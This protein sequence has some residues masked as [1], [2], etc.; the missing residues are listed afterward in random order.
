M[1]QTESEGWRRPPSHSTVRQQELSL[2]KSKGG[3]CS[4][5]ADWRRPPTVQSA[6]CFT[7]AMDSNGSLIQKH[8]HRST[9][10]SVWP[11]I[12]APCGPVRLTFTHSKKPFL[13]EDIIKQSSFSVCNTAL[14][15]QN[16]IGSQLRAT[17]IFQTYSF[18]SLLDSSH[19]VSPLTVLITPVHAVSP[20]IPTV[21]RGTCGPPSDQTSSTRVVDHF[22]FLGWEH[23]SLEYYLTVSAG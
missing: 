12:W 11:N 22:H 7:W 9:Q 15:G 21:G 17:P 1:L 18:L 2:I 3:V 20:P 19:S 16:R 4:I 6:V 23:V 8:P 13:S 14:S 5:Q 10:D